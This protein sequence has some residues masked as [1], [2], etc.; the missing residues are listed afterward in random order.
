[1]TLGEVYTTPTKG[2]KACVVTCL[3]HVF[4]VTPKTASLFAGGYAVMTPVLSMDR[5]FL[6]QALPDA[7][8]SNGM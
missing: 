7:R 3:V 1:M 2:R 8:K 5:F 4:P 6:H